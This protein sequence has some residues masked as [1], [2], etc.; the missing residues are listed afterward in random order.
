MLKF[1]RAENVVA[2]KQQRRAYERIDQKF[3][4]QLEA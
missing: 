1:Q 2:D 4:E 3:D